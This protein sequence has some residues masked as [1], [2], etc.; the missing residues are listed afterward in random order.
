MQVKAIKEAKEDEAPIESTTDVNTW[1]LEVERVLPL[2]K[3]HVRADNKVI[4]VACSELT[5]FNRLYAGLAAALGA[6]SRA[7]EGRAAVHVS[8]AGTMTPMLSI[9]SFTHVQS[10][11]QAAN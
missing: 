6:D 5:S 9:Y 3:V 7:R 1:R 11:G 10:V 4:S 2:L 8:R